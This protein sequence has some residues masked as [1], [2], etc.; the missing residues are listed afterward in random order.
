MDWRCPHYLLPSRRYEAAVLLLRWQ[1]LLP[2]T[3]H[4]EGNREG[5]GRLF[6]DRSIMLSKSFQHTGG[7]VLAHEHCLVRKQGSSQCWLKR[8]GILSIAPLQAQLK[9]LNDQLLVEDVLWI[10]NKYMIFCRRVSIEN[11]VNFNNVVH[12]ILKMLM[13]LVTFSRQHH[14]DIAQEERIYL[15]QQIFT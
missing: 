12:V 15:S 1:R 10:L 13:Y 8:N 7:N 3:G 4:R 11:M 2:S 5:Q 14:D 6:G 9:H